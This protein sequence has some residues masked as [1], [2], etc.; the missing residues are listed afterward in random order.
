MGELHLEIVKD[1]ILNHYDAKALFGDLYIAYR[2]TIDSEVT[3]DYTG[4]FTGSGGKSQEITMSIKLS[5]N[6]KENKCAFKVR[7]PFL[8]LLS[9]YVMVNVFVA[10]GG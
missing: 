6:P 10:V 4:S 5:R 9:P 7:S 8:M 2:S 1:K 3:Y